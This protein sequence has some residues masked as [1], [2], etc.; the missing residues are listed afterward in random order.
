[1]PKYMSTARIARMR[2]IPIIRILLVALLIPRR[3]LGHR[4]SLL[5]RINLGSIGYFRSHQYDYGNITF[6]P[7]RLTRSSFIVT[8]LRGFLCYLPATRACSRRT[9]RF[10]DWERSCGRKITKPSRIMTAYLEALTHR[11]PNI[12]ISFNIGYSCHDFVTQFWIICHNG[13]IFYLI[14]IAYFY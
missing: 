6:E 14:E 9:G 1:M 11:V 7:Y 12:A 3:S 4:C 2:I 5:L 8:R 10:A 13:F